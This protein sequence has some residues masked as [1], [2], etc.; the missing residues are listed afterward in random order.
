M[1]KESK[2][3]EEMEVAL[4]SARKAGEIMD[5]YAG[6]KAKVEGNKTS[7]NDI[8]TEADLKCQEIIVETIT[9]AFPEDSFIAEEDLEYKK[10]SDNGRKWIIDPIDG[11]SNFQRGL[12]YF[13]TSIAFEV[14]GDKKLGVVYSPDEGI[15]KLFF[16][17]KG[18]GAFAAE[19][20]D[21]IDSAEEISVSDVREKSGSL[22]FSRITN[23]EGE[24]KDQK[25]IWSSMAEEDI[26]VRY[27]SAGALELCKV[28]SGSGEAF[29]S[30]TESLWDLAAGELIV[31]EANGEVDIIE[32]KIA[33]RQRIIASNGNIHD[34]LQDLSSEFYE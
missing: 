29:I 15:S 16:A 26:A 17:L 5:E 10:E 18:Q 31:R 30:H 25:N 33:G 27:M 13:C 20:P 4:E 19:N 23:F 12:D 6:G 22:V 24:H 21:Q 2:F 11:T 9:E 14:D 28:A 32:S 34:F 8:Y 7:L 1:F 3:S